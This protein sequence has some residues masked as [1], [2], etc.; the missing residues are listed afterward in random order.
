MR[1]T[2]AFDGEWARDGLRTAARAGLI[3]VCAAVS[4]LGMAALAG[5]SAWA[6]SDL[7]IVKDD[8]DVTFGGC[9]VTQPLASGRI[10]VR[11]IGDQ[12]ATLELGALTRFTRSM[13]AVYEPHNP[14]M[15]DLAKEHTVLDPKEQQTIAFTVGAGVVKKGRLPGSGGAGA[16]A[17]LDVS[18]LSRDQK[19]EIQRALHDVRQYDGPI[20]GSFGG[21]Y[22]NA[23]VG[24]QRALGQNQ[25]GVLTV[26]QTVTLSE[27]S[28]RSLGS[29]G[30]SGGKIPV[31]IYAV[32]DPYNLIEEDDESNNLAEF[33]GEISCN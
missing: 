27:R 24:F 12:R 14:D 20:D 13:L 2:M 18:A 5:G 33:R 28:H 4:G 19:R 25:T 3:C 6:K 26:A 15:V 32:V 31:V 7:V 29:G 21:G 30:A 16:G 11:N 9:G 23:V 1:T 10:A 8:S 22:R 17:V